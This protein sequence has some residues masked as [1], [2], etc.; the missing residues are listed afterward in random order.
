MND[1]SS[2]AKKEEDIDDSNP[3]IDLGANFSTHHLL[4]AGM[5]DGAV[6]LWDTHRRTK[7]ILQLNGHE[8]RVNRLAFHPLG[9]LLATTSD[10]LTWRLWDVE[11]GKELLTQE[12]HSERKWKQWESRPKKFLRPIPLKKF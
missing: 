8:A 6:L 12:G 7:P 1:G 3:A 10:D 4:A 2:I 11:A 9:H 5:A